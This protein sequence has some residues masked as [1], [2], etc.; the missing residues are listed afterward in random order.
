MQN[1]TLES[2]TDGETLNFDIKQ[3]NT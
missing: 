3:F 2:P 1:L